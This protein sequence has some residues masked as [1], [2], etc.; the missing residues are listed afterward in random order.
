M[1][2]KRVEPI[3]VRISLVLEVATRKEMIK[4]MGFAYDTYKT[5]R[6][7]D[8][9]PERRL[10]DFAEKHGLNIQWLITGEGERYKKTTEVPA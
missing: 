4:K 7:L 5:W 6:H 3:F 2:T 10:N 8:R 9:I 1:S